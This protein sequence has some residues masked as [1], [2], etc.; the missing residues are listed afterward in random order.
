AA[1]LAVSQRVLALLSNL[2]EYVRVFLLLS[3]GVSDLLSL[4]AEGISLAY[5]QAINKAL[6]QSGATIVEMNYVRK[7]LSA[8]NHERLAQAAG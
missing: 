8:I 6:L 2:R 1:G 5:K 4:P 3:G 7:H